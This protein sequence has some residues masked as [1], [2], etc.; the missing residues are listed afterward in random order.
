MSPYYKRKASNQWRKGIL[1]ISTSLFLLI[2]VIPALIVAPKTLQTTEEKP[3]AE[4]ETVQSKEQAEVLAPDD[5][6]FSV[7]VI[8]TASKKNETVLLED[9]VTRVVASEM[10]ADFEMEALKAQALAA[11]TYIV[12]YLAHA[13]EEQQVTDTVEHQVYKNDEELQQ[14]WGAD[15]DWKMQK[16]K[17]AVAA[18]VGKIITYE[19]EP[20][21][22]AFFSTSNGYTENA[23][24]YWENALPYLKSVASPW[25]QDSPKYIDQ[26]TFTIDEVQQ[27]LGVSITLNDANFPITRTESNRVKTIDI[28]GET[29]TGREIRESLK[30]QSTDFEVSTKNDHL[31]FTT[32]GYGHGIGM[33]QY[34][35]NGMA[36]EGKSYEE[37]V[38]YY[39]QG[40]SIQT[41]KDTTPTLVVQK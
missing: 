19:N 32:K 14:T 10:P 11:R 6:A 35:A 25:D 15:Y 21:T 2:L 31:I 28:G 13:G 17:E 18:T 27:T 8:R 22:P 38:S 3:N 4:Q 1:F 33:S 23:E 24:D 16:I 7:D 34:G 41:I 9:Y 37:I 12:Q 30:L 36:K 5:S 39:Y 29:F 26:K 40:V 20:I